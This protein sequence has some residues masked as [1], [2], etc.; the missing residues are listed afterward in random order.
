MRAPVLPAI[1][2]LALPGVLASVTCDGARAPLLDGDAQ[3]YL[4]H[5]LSCIKDL[6]VTGDAS[7]VCGSLY[8]EVKSLDKEV[9]VD[10]AGCRENFESIAHQCMAIE[11]GKGGSIIG[12][13]AQYSIHEFMK[14]IGPENDALDTALHN[15][16][17]GV[18]GNKGSGKTKK[19]SKSGRKGSKKTSGKGK[20][21]KTGKKGKKGKKTGKKTSDTTSATNS[22]SVANGTAEACERKGAK[23][24]K[25]KKNVRDILESFLSSSLLPRAP[26]DKGKGKATDEEEDGC[27]PWGEYWKRSLSTNVEHYFFHKAEDLGDT[28]AYLTAPD[29]AQKV[30]GKMKTGGFLNVISFSGPNQNTLCVGDPG[31]NNPKD[32]AAK[33]A[34]A[35]GKCVIT[36]GN[37][38]VLPGNSKMTLSYNGPVIED[39]HKYKGYSIGFTSTDPEEKQ[40]FPLPSDYAGYY[41]RFE[42]TDGSYMW[43]GPDL[44]KELRV[45]EPE[46]CPD[47]PRAHDGTL[48]DPNKIKFM[49]HAYGSIPGSLLH[50]VGPA[51]RLVTVIMSDTNKFIF[52]LTTK[53]K[54][55]GGLKLND[56]RDLID[57]FL[58]EFTEAK[59]DGISGAKQA[60]NMDGGGSV[61]VIW[62]KGN[63]EQEVLAAGKME[64]KDEEADGT[65]NNSRARTVQTIV[66]HTFAKR[67]IVWDFGF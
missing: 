40:T 7:K 66:K 51:D 38:F 36:N 41:E 55:K 1:F 67:R 20:K 28:A 47:P 5:T 50:A 13:N 35:G 63:G 42:G 33:E 10:D 6:C 26:G 58:K 22:T 19:T 57:T 29:A 12:N 54:T 16:R 37:F 17:R 4:N 31:R 65:I 43:C 2:S 62:V 34:K 61:Y 49:R 64:P 27:R 30:F 9:S 24:K 21:K 53:N 45:S 23:T 60:L 15:S 18:S 56:M 46:F 52:S 8:L 25:G 48:E 44:K 39:V 32:I 11:H 59:E 14:E 3:R